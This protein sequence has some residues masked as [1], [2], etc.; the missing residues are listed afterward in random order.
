MDPLDAINVDHP[1]L[2]QGLPDDE[3]ETTEEEMEEKIPMDLDT[4]D[5]EPIEENVGDTVSINYDQKMLKTLLEKGEGFRKP[6]TNFI[7]TVDYIATFFDHKEFD[8]AENAKW[9]VGDPSLPEGLSSAIQ[10]MRK[11]EK[12]KLKF[13]KR[14]AFGPKQGGEGLKFPPGYEEGENKEFIQNHGVIYEVRMKDWVHRETIG[15]KLLKS[16]H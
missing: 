10:H 6:S 1:E 14:L 7:C 4:D 5:V 11:G 12:A 13:K 2:H 8:R 15:E 3:D 16:I 9:I